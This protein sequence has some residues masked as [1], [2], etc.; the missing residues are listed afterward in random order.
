MVKN[1][2]FI[3][4]KQSLAEKKLINSVPQRNFNTF[5]EN[6]TVAYTSNS[7]EVLNDVEVDITGRQ[8]FFRFNA[9]P[10]SCSYAIAN[11]MGQVIAKGEISLENQRLELSSFKPGFY[12]LFLM[13]GLERKVIPFK[14]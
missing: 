13:R 5:V 11:Q 3:L 10:N 1:K 4:V 14:I 12:N 6:N 9:L 2:Y 8:L 7:D